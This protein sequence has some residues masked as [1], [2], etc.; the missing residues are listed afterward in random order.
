MKIFLFLIQEQMSKEELAVVN[1]STSEFL[2]V[3]KMLPQS[4]NAL[5]FM[6]WILRTDEPH[7]LDVFFLGRLL[8]DI[9]CCRVEKLPMG[10]IKSLKFL[11]EI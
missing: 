2:A 10:I 11:S 7:G 6:G 4:G 3:K 8:F 5:N 9:H 1:F